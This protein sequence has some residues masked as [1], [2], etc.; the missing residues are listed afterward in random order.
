MEFVFEY[1]IHCIGYIPP[2]AT[3]SASHDEPTYVP[4]SSQIVC[5]GCLVS[6]RT[7]YLII[8]CLLFLLYNSSPTGE[9]YLVR[10][11][12][13]GKILLSIG[14]RLF[15]LLVSVPRPFA[16]LQQIDQVT[17]TLHHQIVTVDHITFK[18][19]NLVNII[20]Y[21]VNII[22][23]GDTHIHEPLR[24]VGRVPMGQKSFLTYHS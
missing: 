9:L 2:L 21:L 10:S 18:N 19:I 15:P 8:T 24:W 13:Q 14:F 3:H 23:H 7:R 17:V 5:Q 16:E 12:D 1:H 22:M 11:Y 20:M 4:S 6:F